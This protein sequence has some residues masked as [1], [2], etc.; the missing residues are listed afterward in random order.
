MARKRTV[1][2]KKT[3]GQSPWVLVRK[4]VNQDSDRRLPLIRQIEDFYRARTVTYF[5]SFSNPAAEISD[6]DAEMLE[7]ILAVEHDKGKLLL[8]LNSPGGQALAA[9]RIVNVWS[10]PG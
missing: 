1:K 8:I 5:T 3:F 10:Y 2:R 7:S 6:E 9:E 4:E